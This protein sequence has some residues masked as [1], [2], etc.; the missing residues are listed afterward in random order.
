VFK[1]GLTRDQTAFRRHGGRESLFM[2]TRVEKT[3]LFKRVLAWT[4]RL[5]RTYYAILICCTSRW[6]AESNFA[7]AGSDFSIQ[8]QRAG[9]RPWSTL[10]IYQFNWRG[11]E[12][13]DGVR[14]YRPMAEDLKALAMGL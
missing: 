4:N 3:G 2:Q 13:R 7:N 8:V 9:F 11:L 1:P 12:C 5:A 14:C 10:N 6:S